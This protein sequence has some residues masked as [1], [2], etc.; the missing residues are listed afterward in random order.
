[1]QQLNRCHGS[2]KC[3]RLSPPVASSS[4]CYCFHRHT[5]LDRSPALHRVGHAGA[6]ALLHRHAASSLVY[7]GSSLSRRVQALQLLLIST[8]ELPSSQCLAGFPSLLE[9]EIRAG[10]C[11]FAKPP[12]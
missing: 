10:S 3:P 1:M 8:R 5:R 9:F 6:C 4:L 7:K 11:L 12:N 2:S